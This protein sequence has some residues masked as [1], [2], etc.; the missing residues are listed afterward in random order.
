MHLVELLEKSAG[1]T[2]ES[3]RICIQGL[4]A[5]SRDVEPGYLFAA[6]PGV[7]QDGAIFIEKAL[8]K[9]AAAIITHEG[10]RKSVSTDALKKFENVPVVDCK[11]PRH[12][13]AIA[14]ARYY[15]AQPETICAVT[16]TNG[17]TS[18][19]S[20]VRQIWGHLGVKAAS[21]GT[22]GVTGPG[23]R[24]RLQHTTPDPVRI[25]QCL[26]GLVQAGVTHLALEASSHGLA[27]HRLDGVVIKLAAFTN[28]TRDHLDYHADFED[29]LYSKMR[30]FGEVLQPGATAVL[31]A[32]IP[33]Y[34]EIEHMCWARGL[35]ITSVGSAGK[36]LRLKTRKARS[37]G[38]TLEVEWRGQPFNVELPLVGAFQASNALL[39]AAMVIETGQDAA[40]VFAALSSLEGA[41]G[42]L[43]LAGH[44]KEGAA[45]FV[46][47]AHTPDALE[48]VLQALRSHVTGKLHVII[49]CGGDRD[50]GKRALMGKTAV[51]NADVVIVTDDNPRGEDPATIREQV[52]QGAKGAHNIGDRG[53][54][55]RQGILALASGDILVIAGKGHETGQ[56][57]GDM[58]Y[59]F[60]DAQE[61]GKVLANIG[62]GQ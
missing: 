32:D 42:R 61:V 21:M 19:A 29:Y 35:V 37:S 53:E 14:A 49:G 38:Q 16:G 52:M 36:T 44:T 40:E 23:V 48:T 3:A 4:T 58:V 17:K 33:E 54:A 56:T 47:Y 41:P 18:V 46:D 8:G 2:E 34:E 59:P 50:T 27:Q 24:M 7:E 9:G 55:I 25:H 28:L 30:L 6:L 10:W 13:L 12:S 62:G 57:V 1:L 45:I 5:D 43:E 31:N 51:D 11:N 26:K 60:N 15:G 39:A 22:L 20:F